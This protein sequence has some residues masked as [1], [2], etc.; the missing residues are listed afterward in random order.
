MQNDSKIAELTKNHFDDFIESYRARFEGNLQKYL[1]DYRRETELFINKK[2]EI[3][4]ELFM[5]KK[6]ESLNSFEGA[7]STK[8]SKELSEFHCQLNDAKNGILTDIQSDQIK[9][10]NEFSN[11]AKKFVNENKQNLGDYFV[12]E[13]TKFIYEL[14]KGK[15]KFQRDL[16]LVS[17]NVLEQSLEKIHDLIGKQRELAR[18]E[19]DSLQIFKAKEFA[20]EIETLVKTQNEQFRSEVEISLQY[21][22]N[23]FENDLKEKSD[24]LLNKTQCHIQELVS[25]TKNDFHSYSR[26]RIEELKEDFEEIASD[27]SKQV[28]T[29]TNK[30]INSD[31][32]VLVE[33]L[34]N[35]K[36][37]F[38]SFTNQ[39][40]NE[41][42]DHLEK[43]SQALK[44]EIQ[45]RMRHLTESG[46]QEL[47]QNI[48][49]RK[50]VCNKEYAEFLNTE[51][52]KFKDEFI[53][54]V[55]QNIETANTSFNTKAEVRSAEILDE[56]SKKF[57]DDAIKKLEECECSLS[58]F[59]ETRKE[60]LRK[61]ISDSLNE[62]LDRAQGIFIENSQTALNDSLRDIYAKT[63]RAIQKIDHMISEKSEQLSNNCIDILQES[64]REILNEYKENHR[65][66]KSLIE[67]LETS[68]VQNLKAQVAQIFDRSM[69]DFDVKSRENSQE[70]TLDFTNRIQEEAKRVEL[71]LEKS[72]KQFANEIR[73][74][75]KEYQQALSQINTTAHQSFR[76]SLRVEIDS[77]LDGAGKSCENILTD[78]LNKLEGQSRKRVSLVTGEFNQKIQLVKQ[79]F[80]QIQIEE[81][82]K[83]KESLVKTTYQLERQ[84][85]EKL[86]QKLDQ[87]TV[88]K[89][90]D[91]ISLVSR[92]NDEK[93]SD[94][95]KMS[96]Q[97][98][99]SFKNQTIQELNTYKETTIKHIEGSV[100]KN[101]SALKQNIATIGNSCLDEA[102]KSAGVLLKRYAEKCQNISGTSLE[103]HRNQLEKELK[104]IY[105]NAVLSTKKKI[106]QTIGDLVAVEEQKLKESVY[107]KKRQVSDELEKEMERF[108]YKLDS[109]GKFLSSQFQKSFEQKR[110]ELTNLSD[111]RLAKSQEEV[112]A[113]TRKML[114]MIEFKTKELFKKEFDESIKKMDSYK[115]KLNQD[116]NES[117]QTANEQIKKQAYQNSVIEAKKV[118]GRLQ[119]LSNQIYKNQANKHQHLMREYNKKVRHLEMLIN[120]VK[121]L[122]SGGK[123]LPKPAI[124]PPQVPVV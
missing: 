32:E 48:S 20:K 26:K 6:I 112:E 54:G 104:K 67:A 46:I 53:K 14:G 89:S 96:G 45:Q 24:E 95:K 50:T 69:A 110:T 73:S 49:D 122:N 100:S 92:A 3:L 77:V 47:K 116:I 94:F 25:D 59:T 42:Q 118:L 62:S 1:S 70:L 90:N 63:A 39:Q 91:F 34:N 5:D 85:I 30:S 52:K 58:E 64:K 107:D 86:N 78:H 16:E 55:S 43:Q 12:S 29:Q 88:T 106:E 114:S 115:S 121:D 27:I 84:H 22:L 79:R 51:T 57:F 99:L 38:L 60:N 19:L 123:A 17:V 109:I 41:A 111:E 33:N 18:G 61:Q 120:G 37:D 31:F 2:E 71:F 65:H 87:A 75:S 44:T 35:L 81:E 76:D 72:K 23:S 83:L 66:Y 93:L 113:K 119:D 82:K 68:Q 10:L 11:H 40:N 117:V 102:K 105:E 74:K 7:V 4:S 8:I 36:K 15:D 103:E 13:K 98:S 21:I 9:L 80:D 101:T 124:R 56:I 28:K 108:G 97:L